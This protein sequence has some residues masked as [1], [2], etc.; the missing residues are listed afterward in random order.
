MTIFERILEAFTRQ[1][2]VITSISNKLQE[3]EIGKGGGVGMVDDTEGY[4]NHGEI[5]NTYEGQ[6]KNK[7]TNTAAHAEGTGVWAQG[8]GSHAEGVETVA[9]SS[10]SHAEGCSTTASGAYSHAEGYDTTA[11]SS[12]CHA[13]GCSTIA[14]GYESHAEGYDTHATGYA[15]HAEGMSNTASGAET[16]AEGYNT[17]ASGDYSHAEGENTIAGRSSHAEGADT[18][19]QNYSHSEG[20][21][22]KAV[23]SYSHAGG[24]ESEARAWYSFTHGYD[25]YVTSDGAYAV[26]MHNCAGTMSVSEIDDIYRAYSGMTTVGSSAQSGHVEGEY[27]R[28]WGGA[29]HAEGTYNVVYGFTSHAEGQRNLIGGYSQSPDVRVR[30]S[31]TLDPAHNDMTPTAC[32]AE[33]LENNVTGSAAHVE[34]SYVTVH[35]NYAHGEGYNNKAWATAAHAEGHGTKASGEYGS[36]SEGQATIAS[37]QSSHAE[38]LTAVASGAKAHAEGEL[39]VAEGDAAHAEGKGAHAKSLDSHAEGNYT[40]ANGTTAHV[41]GMG[42]KVFTG[43]T[44]CHAEGRGSLCGTVEEDK[45][46]EVMDI[47]NCYSGLTSVGNSSSAGHAEGQNTRCWGDYCHAEGDRT[48]V[49]NAQSSH[50]EGYFN[51]IGNSGPDVNA[52]CPAATYP[53]NRS[54]SCSYSHCEGSTNHLVGMQSHCEGYNNHLHADMAH[55]EGINQQAYG[56]CSHTEGMGNILGDP[57]GGYSGLCSHIEGRSNTLYGDYAHVEGYTNIIEYNHT[58]EV[59]NDQ[60]HTTKGDYTHL[61][62]RNHTAKGCIDSHLEGNNHTAYGE[63]VHV[64]GKHNTVGLEGE[65][66]DEGGGVGYWGEDAG[67]FSH[68]EGKDNVTTSDAI[69]CEGIGN[70]V[71]GVLSHCEGQNNLVGN[72]TPGWLG[73]RYSHCEGTDNVCSNDWCH[74]EGGHNQ[75]TADYQ[76]I[77]GKYNAPDYYAMM[78]I[79]N[80]RIESTIIVPT[81]QA[82]TYYTRS[83]TSPNYTYTLQSSKP[84]NW[85]TFFYRYYYKEGNEYLAV[86]METTDVEKRMNIFAI[87]DLGNLNCGQ[88]DENGSFVRIVAPTWQANTYYTRGGTY[89]NYTYTLQ[90]SKPSNWDEYYMYYFYKDGD[91]YYNV[92]VGTEGMYGLVN[93]VDLQQLRKDVDR[94][95]AHLGI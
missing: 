56:Q 26:G 83:G 36:H 42:T 15:S 73:G 81:W 72:P 65:W 10:G 14:S 88:S 68:V 86:P 9:G 30:Y 70:T 84:S 22:T 19:A 46:S 93:G 18:I 78:M 95:L 87:D 37:G 48:I 85:D 92:P 11:S 17:L 59:H 35:G 53:R 64:E 40:Y 5:F 94:I 61:E 7:A 58:T 25:N 12:Y 80:G 82:N 2:T 1:N 27:N 67:A 3:L 16:H 49:M 44:Q 29:A 45:M 23:G 8:V 31:A 38:G 76:H 41:E 34:G 89:P 57:T 77:S 51:V 24:Y 71:K 69:H 91:N 90:T 33:G 74:V 4:Q 39:T 52:V 54:L 20:R 79:G 50:V 75:T 66:V 13:E 28:V 63:A 32:H 6:N 21:R 62:G 47:H 60:V 43:S 55:V